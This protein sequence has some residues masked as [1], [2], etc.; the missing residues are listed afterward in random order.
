VE[1]RDE[2]SGSEKTIYLFGVAAGLAT[3][4]HSFSQIVVLTADEAVLKQRINERKDNNFGKA[5]NELKIILRW[6]EN[7]VASYQKQG[8]KVIDTS[9]SSPEEVADMLVDMVQKESQEK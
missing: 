3:V 5:P 4:R 9:H 7:H 2:A 8:A 1:L 6:Q